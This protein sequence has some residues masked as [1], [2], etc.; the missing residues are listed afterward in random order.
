MRLTPRTGAAIAAL[1]IVFAAATAEAATIT[2]TYVFSFTD[3]VP[4]IGAAPPPEAVL[5]GKVTLTFDDA[6]PYSSETTGI[7]ISDYVGP[8]LLSPLSFSS[9]FNG[10]GHG[11][12]IGGSQTGAGLVSSGAGDFVV[13]IR[14]AD[15][16]FDNP[17]LPTCADGFNCGSAPPSALPSGYTVAG[18]SGGWLAQTGSI[19]LAVPEPSTWAMMLMGFGGLGAALRTRRRVAAVA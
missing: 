11:M 10:G 15:A 18:V 14:F 8:T 19:S 5:S 1:G 16:S 4:A 13:Q 7:S 3:F 17:F 6:T 9:F 12:S 2:R